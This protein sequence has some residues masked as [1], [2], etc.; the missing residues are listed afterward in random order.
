MTIGIIGLGRFGTL[1]AKIM[2]LYLDVVAYDVKP[3]RLSKKVKLVA[4]EVAAAQDIVIL[5]VPIR[6]M[7]NVLKRI[8]PFVKK[9]ALV[10]D[11]CSVKEKPVEWM[12]KYL[13]SY[14]SILG[15]HPL[16]GPDTISK[17]FKGNELIITPVRI[18]RSKLFIIEKALKKSGLKVYKISPEEHDRAMAAAQ[19][20]LHFIARSFL[21]LPKYKNVPGTKSYKMIK[22]VFEA[23]NKDTNE[24][25]EDINKYNRFASKIRIKFIAALKELNTRIS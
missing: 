18:S 9:G 16:F 7:K 20:L 22:E 5:A 12:K 13:P 23:L 25:F 8:S 10:C 21:K 15:T 14:V 6:E 17:N 1:T 19:T 3:L 2:S 24:L 4:L 11:V